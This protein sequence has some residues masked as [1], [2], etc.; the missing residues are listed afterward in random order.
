MQTSVRSYDTIKLDLLKRREEFHKMMIVYF[1][2]YVHKLRYY[3]DV[4][5]SFDWKSAGRTRWWCL[6]CTIVHLVQ[7]TSAFVCNVM[8]CVYGAL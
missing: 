4:I 1:A 6:K 7:D 2:R 5:H 3:G 8:Y